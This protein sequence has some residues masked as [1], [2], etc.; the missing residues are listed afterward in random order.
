MSD[1]QPPYNDDNDDDTLEYAEPSRE[2]DDAICEAD[3]RGIADETEFPKDWEAY[4][5][6]E[7]EDTMFDEGSDDE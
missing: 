5:F 7:C 1:K 6:G 3:V 4:W 2:T